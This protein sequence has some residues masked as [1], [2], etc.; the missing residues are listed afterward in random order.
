M[1][2]SDDQ[3]VVKTAT[4]LVETLKESFH[5]P[6]GFRPAHAKGALLKGTFTPTPEASQLSIAPQFTAPTETIVRFSD[7]PGTPTIA[8]TDTSANPRGL[9][10]R[11]F[12]GDAKHTDIITQSTHVFP[13]RTGEE[14]LELLQAMAAG[15]TDDFLATHPAAK[16]A[17]ETPLQFAVGFETQRYFSIHA[18]KLID[19]GGKATFVRYQ[20]APQTVRVLDPSEVKSKT[21]NYMFDALNETIAQGPIKMTLEAQI[22]E[23]GDV[24]DD[25]TMYWPS[26]RKLVVLGTLEITAIL[27]EGET[28]PEQKRLIF[29]PIPR[30]LGIERSDDPLLDI[31]STAYLISGRERRAA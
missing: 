2:H 7:S 16:A 11:F 31:R 10:C 4:E 23:D 9:A 8:D 12:F 17:L 5:T 21:A 22:A 1:S 26:S 3:N 27:E 6:P 13:T 20:F 29:D 24:T 25:A 15:K 30:V 14:F 19:A 18:F 28:Q